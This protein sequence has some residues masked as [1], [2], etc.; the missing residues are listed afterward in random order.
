MPKVKFI[1]E[2]VTI[3]VPEG[4][5]LREEAMKNG[6]QVYRGLRRFVHCRGHG[7][8]AMCRV[9][10]H[11]GME[12]ASPKSWW[13]RFRLGISMVS[14]G[15]EDKMRLSCQTRVMGDLEVETQPP[16]NMSGEKFW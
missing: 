3:E 2:H 8:C 5:N 6:I 14:I 12:N 4:A 16:L 10:V 15:F 11:Q 1:N 13:E 9:L 7:S